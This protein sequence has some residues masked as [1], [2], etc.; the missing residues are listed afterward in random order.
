[1]TNTGGKNSKMKKLLKNKKAL[2]PVV[3]AIILIAVTV[4]V[5]IAVA[6]WMGSMTF[7]FMETEELRVSSANFNIIT[8]GTNDD[9]LDLIVVNT[10]SQQVDFVAVTVN[11]GSVSLNLDA[12]DFDPDLLAAGGSTTITVDLGADVTAGTL[13]NIEL[14]TAAGNTYAYQETA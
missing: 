5:S 9:T 11:G 8:A 4:A 7:N 1:V 2:S 13:Y 3:A 14:I 10:G 6:A 12:T